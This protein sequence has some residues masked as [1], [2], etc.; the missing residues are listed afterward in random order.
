MVLVE[1]A[2][3]ATI[4][5]GVVFSVIIDIL[6]ANAIIYCNTGAFINSKYT[7]GIF[8]GNII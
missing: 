2:M 6:A 3:L 4:E 5:T 7:N 1:I 8:I